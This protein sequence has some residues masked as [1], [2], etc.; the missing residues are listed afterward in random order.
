M[1]KPT[2]LDQIKHQ[3]RQELSK[4]YKHLKGKISDDEWKEF[5]S[6]FW[7]IRPLVEIDYAVFNSTNISETS[8]PNYRNPPNTGEP[9]E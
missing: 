8:G 1:V 2:P 3:L 7:K 5:E 6:F 9:T 4:A